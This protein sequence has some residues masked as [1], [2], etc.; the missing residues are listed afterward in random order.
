MRTSTKSSANA[1]FACVIVYLAMA[2]SVD[3]LRADPAACLIDSVVLDD[4]T[5][6]VPNLNAQ[7]L[8]A[9]NYAAACSDGATQL[10]N[11]CTAACAVYKKYTGKEPTMQGPECK[12]TLPVKTQVKQ[13]SESRDCKEIKPKVEG[14]Q[15]T[16]TVYCIVSS[17]SCVCDP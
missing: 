13:Y 17:L 4:A 6:S 10:N 12:A 15:S 9:G 1:V 8:C 2:A 5:G 7:S 3:V 11:N 14:A 16:W